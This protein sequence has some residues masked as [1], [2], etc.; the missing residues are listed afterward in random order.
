MK[1]TLKNNKLNLSL[2]IPMLVFAFVLTGC[3]QRPQQQGV[4]RPNDGGTP[5]A[6]GSSTVETRSGTGANTDS[7]SN[8]GVQGNTNA[9]SL[10][11]VPQPQQAF[12]NCILMVQQ[13]PIPNYE[14]PR[15]LECQKI[16][17]QNCRGCRV[18]ED[19]RPIDIFSAYGYSGRI[20]WPAHENWWP[21]LSPYLNASRSH[22]AFQSPYFNTQNFPVGHP[23]ASGQHPQGGGANPFVYCHNKPATEPCQLNATNVWTVSNIDKSYQY[24]LAPGK[25]NQYIYTIV[26]PLDQ[27]C[28]NQ[29]QMRQGVCNPQ[30]RANFGNLLGSF[31][32]TGANLKASGKAIVDGLGASLANMIPQFSVGSI[33]P[34]VSV[35]GGGQYTTTTGGSWSVGSSRQRYTT[36]QAGSVAVG[37]APNNYT[38][39][40]AQ[41]LSIYG[42][43]PSS[44][45]GVYGQYLNYSENY[46]NYNIGGDDPCVVGQGHPGSVWGC[47]N[48]NPCYY[49]PNNC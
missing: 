22:I 13:N 29:H 46:N 25:N 6:T 44:A 2:L 48:I 27:P 11:N 21:E 33:F 42:R 40:S 39:N 26:Q 7:N 24:N 30:F 37:G 17:Y 34:N 4:L 3:E 45:Y 18:D 49:N 12:A 19:L 14:D 41:H 9:G 28:D 16:I 31:E 36:S 35:N 32:Q 23:G 43:Q 5:T 38:Y 8:T 47:Q 20:A 1:K 15:F 10:A